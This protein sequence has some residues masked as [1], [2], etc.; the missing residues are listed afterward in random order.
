MPSPNKK[1]TGIFNG[2]RIPLFVAGEKPGAFSAERMS[3]LVKALNALLNIRVLR[4]AKDQVLIADAG[5]VIEIAT[6][7]AGSAPS[8]ESS[9]V[10]SYKVTAHHGDYL[11][12]RTWDEATQTAGS[13]DVNIAKPHELRN[14]VLTETIDAIEITYSAHDTGAQTRSAT[15]GTT[16]ETQI[17]VPRYLTDGDNPTIIRVRSVTGGTGVAEAP[18]LEDV[19][20]G[21]RA[22]SKQS[23]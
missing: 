13:V 21:G 18:T 23:T 2:L 16:T 15:D 20:P 14:S 9:S 10:T 7:A 17:I 5:T 11:T 19:N 8:G 22:W 6:A 4:G 3:Q 12:C 1:Q